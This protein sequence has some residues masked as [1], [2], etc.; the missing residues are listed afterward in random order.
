MIDENW[1]R[2]HQLFGDAL[3][4][5]PAERADFLAEACGDD[6]QTR[7]EVEALLAHHQAA[8]ADFLR[9]PPAPASRLASGE[10]DHLIGGT[11]GKYRIEKVIA[12]GGMGTVY[13]AIQENPQ[14]TVALKVMKP[15]LSPQSVLRRFEFESQILAR[16]AHPNVAQIYEAGTHRDEAT[17]TTV[18]F[19]AME[20]IPEARTIVEYADERSLSTRERLELFATVCDAIHYGHQKG[21]IHRDL[22][23]GNILVDAS[24]RV[25]IID[26]GVARSTD[27]DV[28]ATS[29]QTDVGQLLGTVQYM[30][31][32]QCEADPLDLD[33]RSDVY[34]LGVVLYELL[35]GELPYDI[36]HSAIHAAARTICEKQ[37]APP[38]SRDRKF[39]GDLDAIVIK[40]LAKDRKRRYQ[41]ALEMGEDIGRHLKREPILA[42]PPS[43]FVR[44]CHSLAR[45]PILATTG[46]CL[47]IG[48]GSLAVSAALV[49][50][51]Y[52]EPDTLEISADRLAVTLLSRA[53][54]PLHE[55][56]Q[57]MGGIV[58]ATLVER[59]KAM[60]GGKLAIIAFDGNLANT[61]PGSLCAYDTTGDMEK[62]VWVGRMTDAQMPLHLREE[63]HF[64]AKDS[65]ACRL[66]IM[67]VYP[68]L[69]GDEIVAVHEIMSTTHCA[70]RIYALDGQIL[71][72]AW[73]DFFPGALYWMSGPRL[74]VMHGDN[75]S[76]Y[77]ERRG[78]PEMDYPYPR[79]VFAIRVDPA[80]KT[81]EYLREIPGDG[82]LDPVWYKCFLPPIATNWVSMESLDAPTCRYEPEQHVRF[83]F[84]I[85]NN[86]NNSIDW[87]LDAKGNEVP[88]SRVIADSFKREGSTLPDPDQIHLGDLPPV[89]KGG[90]E[91]TRS[92][93]EPG[94][95]P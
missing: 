63:R 22:K 14:R 89:Q 44:L 70:L 83:R 46:V 69:P 7:D 2:V 87:I 94:G 92:M 8:P 9:P 86:R 13:E 75:G 59:P 17:G 71:Y 88:G 58:L 12:A 80:V 34:S 73:M 19:F 36:R 21:V 72:Q 84:Q 67:D 68:D 77:W 6:P 20:Y 76:A 52:L 55:W 42:R 33:I 3:G 16:L 50:R 95:N 60:G 54:R 27:S 64:T 26:F 25:K 39:R 18:P 51:H 74:L 24:G 90:P 48:G 62:P 53:G 5:E 85:E 30:S 82:A 93:E 81:L 11:V 49:W 1:E 45:H 61:Y 4:R 29:M 28:A 78:H 47:L 23:P 41:S 66:E 57:E 65:R 15:W 10:P 37:P 38:G 79:V 40:A 31:P 91:S 43:R 35:C 32:E 56:A